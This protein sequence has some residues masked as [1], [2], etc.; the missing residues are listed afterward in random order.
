[1]TKTK[2]SFMFNLVKIYSNSFINYV[3]AANRKKKLSYD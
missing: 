1:M 2:F 3:N